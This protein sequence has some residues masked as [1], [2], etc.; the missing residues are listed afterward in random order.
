MKDINEVLKQSKEYG[1]KV[2]LDITRVDNYVSK[3][4]N[5]FNLLKQEEMM[6]LVT[7]D[8]KLVKS[9]KLNIAKAKKLVKEYGSKHFMNIYFRN[10]ETLILVLGENVP[11]HPGNKY[12]G[13]E[14]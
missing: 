14:A 10:R 4:E 3:T 12:A 2:R 1:R 6:V 11:E 7:K 13:E 5:I 8:G 9:D